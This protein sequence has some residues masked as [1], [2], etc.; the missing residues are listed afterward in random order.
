[1]KEPTL[2]FGGELSLINKILMLSKTTRWT[3]QKSLSCHTKE[4]KNRPKAKNITKSQSTRTY[5][6]L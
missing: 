5:V 1:M 2:P 4:H 6:P 3:C